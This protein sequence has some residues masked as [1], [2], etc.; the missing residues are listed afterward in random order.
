MNDFRPWSL[1]EC[2][3]YVASNYWI[4]W[5]EKH[6]MIQRLQPCWI[7][8]SNTSAY[9]WRRSV[10]VF[11]HLSTSVAKTPRLSATQARR[12][13]FLKSQPKPL[14]KVWFFFD[15]CLTCTCITQ[16]HSVLTFWQLEGQPARDEWTT[17]TAPS[18]PWSAIGLGRCFFPDMAANAWLIQR[19]CRWL[20]P[21]AMTESFWGNAGLSLSDENTR[22]FPHLAN[23]GHWLSRW[24]PEF[25]VQ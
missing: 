21:T 17:L 10:N 4:M 13:V 22:T 20:I 19:E 1:E 5:Q 6:H 24:S 15:K 11:L 2:S 23:S 12:N 8:R 9:M 16:L 7:V 3:E 25:R 18:R 14:P